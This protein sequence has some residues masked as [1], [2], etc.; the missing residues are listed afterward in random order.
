MKQEQESTIPTLYFVTFPTSLFSPQL[1]FCAWQQA[2]KIA[3]EY[4][5]GEGREEMMLSMLL[6]MPSYAT[7]SADTRSTQ[8]TYWI[9]AA[10]L[11]RRE[12]GS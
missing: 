9:L 5:S 8:L 2:P 10:P 4:Q 12:S 7:G 1:C 3:C 11:A 6:S